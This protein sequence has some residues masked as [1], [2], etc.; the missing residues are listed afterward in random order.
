[1]TDQNV[2]V[3]KFDGK[4]DVRTVA[5]D[6]GDVL[7]VAKDVAEALGYSDTKQAVRIHCK[8]AKS[9]RE[10][11]VL[12]GGVSST[13]L[14]PQ[15]KLVPEADVFRLALRSTLPSAERFQDW[16]EEEV[17]PSIR[18]TGGYNVQ[19]QPPVH[20]APLGY[21]PLPDI[22]IA[23]LAMR[24]L[25]LSDTSKIRMMTQMCDAHGV[26]S[27]FLPAYVDEDLVRSLTQLLKDHGSSLS[28]R[29]ANLALVDMGILTEMDRIGSG[30]KVKKFKNLTDAGLKYGRNE[31]SPQNPRETQPLYF[32]KA[33]PELLRRIEAH[34]S[35]DDAA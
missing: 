2:A 13:P 10:I 26:S 9:L 32:V 4:F 24:T 33:F 35:A 5:T 25:R 6:E 12:A 16:V 14:D 22:Q 20:A 19:P 34:M 18:K 11:G 17:L 7:F 30:G 27:Q 28:A 31:T 29:A 15:T 8:R 21:L 3:F 23:E 1:M